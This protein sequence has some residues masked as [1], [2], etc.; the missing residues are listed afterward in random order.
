MGVGDLAGLVVKPAVTGTMRARKTKT[1]QNS[2]AKKQW[3]GYIGVAI[4]TTVLT[5]TLNEFIERRFAAD[6][7]DVG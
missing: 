2:V 6:D 5:K 7:A 4:L 1:R 3:I